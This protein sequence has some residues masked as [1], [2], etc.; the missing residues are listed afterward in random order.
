MVYSTFE[1]IADWQISG[2]RAELDGLDVIPLGITLPP[3]SLH[4]NALDDWFDPAVGEHVAR[5]CSQYNFAFVLIHY[6]WMSA[7]SEYLPAALPRILYTHDRFGERHR[8]LASAGIAPTWYSISIP[9]EAR[10]L[11]RVDLVIATQQE[12]ADYFQTLT[13]R[14]VHVLGSL[15]ALRERIVPGPVANGRLRVGY[16]GSANPG[17][18]RSMDEFIATIDCNK[19]LNSTNFELVLGGPISTLSRYD[20]DYIVPL[21]VL[22]R[23]EE[24]FQ[25]VDVMINPSVGGSGLKI[26]TVECLAAGMPLVSTRD[27]MMGLKAL[28]PALA[29]QDAAEVAFELGNLTLPGALE[30]LSHACRETIELYAGDQI[31]N[32]KYI[33]KSVGGLQHV[34]K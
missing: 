10:G 29:C 27:G 11:E 19:I 34:D 8:M 21:G 5:L 22:N 18:C 20:R 3:P 2:M 28:H 7:I 16:L 14:P 15:Q 32:F 17:N 33:L 6:V 31:R 4:G 9:D 1:G 25:V 30:M 24:L 13:G 26:K 12:E 23:I